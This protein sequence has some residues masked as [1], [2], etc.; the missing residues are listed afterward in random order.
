VRLRTLAFVAAAATSVAAACAPTSGHGDAGTDANAAQGTIGDQCTRVYSALCA[1]A[2]NDCA[3][4]ATL[5]DCVANG[6]AACCVDR[7]GNAAIT[8]DVTVN[9]CANALAVESCNDV[10]TN[11][12]PT[13]CNGVPA[14]Q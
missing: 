11:A 9:V 7:C 12:K 4:A 13:S 5:A 1:H 2:I 3:V 10:A 8:P 14:T 6:K